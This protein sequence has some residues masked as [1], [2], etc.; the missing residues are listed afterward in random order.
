VTQDGEV[1][2]HAEAGH[3]LR[4][5]RGVGIQRGPE[6]TLDVDGDPVVAYAGETVAAALLAAGHRMVRRT[7][8][9]GEP[10]GLFCGMGVCHDCLM[11]ID[12][13]P[14]VRACLVEVQ[15]GM[16]VRTQIGAGDA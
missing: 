2:K 11:V 7:A 16:T 9:T 6:L 12:G 3:G 10:R 4:V 1:N 5:R 14:S 15:E 8:L 13:Q